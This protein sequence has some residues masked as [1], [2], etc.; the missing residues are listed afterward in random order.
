[1]MKKTIATLLIIF[2]TGC[3]AMQKKANGSHF[4]FG[5]NNNSEA[6]VW[7]EEIIVDGNWSAPATGTLGCGG[8]NI[9]GAPAIGSVPKNTPAPKDTIYLEWYA[10]REMSRMKAVVDL[11]G[12]DVIYPLLLN[13]PWPKNKYNINK[14]YFIIDFRPDHKVWIKL[15]D[16]SSPS[17]QDEV[18]ILA[19]GQ[20]V[21]TDDVVTRYSHFEEGENYKL[22]CTAHRKRIE[23][24]GGY[25]NSLEVYDRW[26]PGA[27]QNKELG[28]E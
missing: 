23:E 19:E 21:K 1:M 4:N 15:A 27:P 26:Y 12:R 17:S 10:W 9:N 25:T 24:L 2:V 14:S 18:M 7:L 11:P 13:P 28:H 5:S 3:S 6:S 20:G 22:D 16:T 8:G